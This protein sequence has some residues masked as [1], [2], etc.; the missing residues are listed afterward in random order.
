MAG[1]ALA[2][3]PQHVLAGLG[4]GSGPIAG[5]THLYDFSTDTDSVSGSQ[6]VT[7]GEGWDFSIRSAQS[8]QAI[9]DP[10]ISVSSAYPTSD[11]PGVTSFPMTQTEPSLPV[12]GNMDFQLSSTLTT[13][14]TI[15]FDSSRSVSPLIVAPGGGQQTVTVTVDLSDR[16]DN[17]LQ[18]GFPLDF[19]GETESCGTASDSAAASC[20][21]NPGGSVTWEGEVDNPTCSSSCLPI[22]QPLTFT[23]ILNVPNPSSNPI[24][25]DPSVLIKGSTCG[26]L[27]NA[28]GPLGNYC[29]NALYTF[30]QTTSITMADPTLDGSIPGSGSVTMSSGDSG[31]TYAWAL[32][33]NDLYRVAYTG[34]SAACITGTING[35]L[36]VAPGQIVC[37]DGARVNGGLTVQSGGTLEMTGSTI[38]GGLTASG[39]TSVDVCA[40][41]ID[42]PTSVQNSSGSVIIGGQGGPACAPNSLNGPVTLADNSA[43]VELIGNTINGPV[44]V[45]NNTG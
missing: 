21:A 29:T 5:D 18:V 26:D 30:P 31:D 25:Y 37:L 38:N 33:D 10:T 27:Y 41:R 40:N 9:T 39:A 20:S 4:P 6:P 45:R 13:Q 22:N 42:G 14:G 19:A 12:G 16:Y 35:S 8:P 2:S 11:F 24:T 3:L 1:L 17:Y 34:A 7:L 32:D 23:A 15:G 44:T 43:G 28:E 36:T